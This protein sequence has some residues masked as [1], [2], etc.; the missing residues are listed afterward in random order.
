MRPLPSPA[1]YGKWDALPTGPA[2]H[3][4]DTS[5]PDVRDGL[6]RRGILIEQWHAY[7]NYPHGFW[8]EDAIRRSPD[9]AEAW[10]NWLLRRSWEAI[11]QINGS[12]RRSSV[13]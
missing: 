6:A 9:Q 3:E 11:S 2:E 4:L 10:R 5:S 8:R 7:R 1:D 13:S 12:L